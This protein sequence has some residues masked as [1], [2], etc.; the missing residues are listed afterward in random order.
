MTSTRKLTFCTIPVDQSYFEA[1]FVLCNKVVV[2]SKCI[3]NTQVYVCFLKGVR[4]QTS[5]FCPS[6]EKG[7]IQREYI[8]P[9]GGEGL[10]ISIVI[11]SIT[12]S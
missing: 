2:L 11:L 10:M 9:E 1:L 5:D 4:V 12:L 6:L 7:T 3:V 8:C